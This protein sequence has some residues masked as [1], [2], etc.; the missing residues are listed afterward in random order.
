[1]ETS[2]TMKIINYM[3]VGLVSLFCLLLAS[4]G[5]DDTEDKEKP[6]TERTTS[7]TYKE[8]SSPVVRNSK[9]KDH[10]TKW[11]CLYFGQ[12]PTNEIVSEPFNAV[13]DYAVSEGEVMMDAT[14]YDRLAKAE[15]AGDDTEIDGKRTI[16]STATELSL[17]L[18]TVSSTTV[19]KTQK[20]G[21]ISS[22]PPSN[23]EFLTSRERKHCSLPT[24]CPTHALSMTKQRM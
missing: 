7:D 11:S 20:P 1:M 9:E 19:G 21:I 14:L 24:V 4:C 16:A 17:A 5:N 8:L 3:T 6:F 2:M 10:V 13:D 12:Y 15:W 23:G 22:T 18:Q